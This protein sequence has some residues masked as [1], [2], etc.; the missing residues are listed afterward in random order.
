[1]IGTY[2]PK[3][4]K[5]SDL[6]LPNAEAKKQ[7]CRTLG[8]AYAEEYEPKVTDT[9]WLQMSNSGSATDARSLFIRQIGNVVCI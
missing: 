4:S 2:L 1:M 7:A 8:A 9:D 6:Q 3:D 5:L